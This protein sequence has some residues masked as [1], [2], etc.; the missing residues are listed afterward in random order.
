MVEFEHLR[1]LC[2]GVG[3]RIWTQA[4]GWVSLQRSLAVFQL[5]ERGLHRL[6]NSGRNLS[7][8]RIPRLCRCHFLLLV[9]LARWC[10]AHL[11]IQSQFLNPLP[12][13]YRTWGTTGPRIKFN[14]DRWSHR[15][16]HAPLAI[17]MYPS[18][19]IVLQM[20]Y[21]VKLVE[22]T[23]KD[24]YTPPRPSSAKPEP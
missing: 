10:E 6:Q 9:N 18:R 14:G 17:R 22:I 21:S 5:G 1:L 11:R 7:I 24:M 16:L 19:R 23:E 3:G 12:Q 2:E 4:E 15:V 20:E 13:I 8:R